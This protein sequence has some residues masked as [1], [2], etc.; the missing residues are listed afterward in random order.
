VAATSGG[1]VGAVEER[2]AGR[3]PQRRWIGAVERGATQDLPTPRAVFYRQAH[4]DEPWFPVQPDLFPHAVWIASTD[5]D[6][7]RVNAYRGQPLL[8]GH[9]IPIPWRRQVPFVPPAAAHP[10]PP[11]SDI[12]LVAMA[13]EAGMDI[14]LNDEVVAAARAIVAALN[15]AATGIC[16]GNAALAVFRT[17]PFGTQSERMEY[18]THGGSVTASLLLNG[19]DKQTFDT[20]I[21]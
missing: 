4:Y 10:T 15:V 16:V 1:D 14:G 13:A 19:I 3:P 8:A 6:A 9:I 18:D 20:M 17:R 2:G 12:A 11:V 21:E 5:D 7:P